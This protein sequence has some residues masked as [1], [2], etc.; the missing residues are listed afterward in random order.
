VVWRET[1]HVIPAISSSSIRN[2]FAVRVGLICRGEVARTNIEVSVGLDRPVDRERS[3]GLKLK[4]VRI[5]HGVGP[6]KIEFLFENAPDFC[7]HRPAAG[8]QSRNVNVNSREIEVAV[9][10]IA[11]ASLFLSGD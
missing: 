2:Y 1:V 10:P 7:R 4:I 6:G 8:P 9:L 3:S 5:K 11:A